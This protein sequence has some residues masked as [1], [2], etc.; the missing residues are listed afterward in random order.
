MSRVGAIIGVVIAMLFLS[1]PALAAEPGV[2][3]LEGQVV[4]GTVG[5]G[6]VAELEVTLKINGAEAGST[7]ARTDAEGKFRFEGLPTGSDYSYQVSLQ[8][9]GADYTSESVSFGAGE[10]SK[11]VEV[12][13]YDS[14]TDDGAI[15]VMTAH[16]II[17]VERDSLLVREFSLVVNGG[18]KTYIG[19]RVVTPDGDKET[20]R[21][22]LPK[23]S[24]QLE[25]ISG[26]MQCC[27]FPSQGGFV[28]IM[29]VM[30]GAKEVAYSYKVKYG[31]SAYSHSAMFYYPTMSFDLLVKG[32]N[33]D[34][35]SD[36][37]TEEEPLDV[38]GKQFIHFSGK[39]IAPGTP[40]A[41]RLSGLP[42]SD[43]GTSKWLAI[44]LVLLFASFALGYVLLRRRPQ[45]V[46]SGDNLDQRR[47]RLL[48]DIAQL[49][50]DFEN[51]KISEELYQKAR[52][53]KKAQLV[54]LM[55]RQG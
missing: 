8:Y 38:G 16:T 11:S 21:F 3:V 5:G 31:S 52:S 7:T 22:S 46:V 49:D 35:S 44:A 29:Q 39:N 1:A 4:N 55:R 6:S 24:S 15:M 41:V 26:L 10:T 53:E 50:D 36:Q 19:S 37:L 14:T 25:V 9:Q 45:P 2:G 51:G 32:A 17:Y 43:Q 13:V 12:P 30:P 27:V 48:S 20:L 34:V 23:D 33:V 18:D 47:Q 40:L 28:D 54:R 42:K